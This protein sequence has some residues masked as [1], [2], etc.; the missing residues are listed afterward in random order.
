MSGSEDDDATRKGKV[1]VVAV[2]T[3]T[4]QRWTRG[5]LRAVILCECL[6][7]NLGDVMLT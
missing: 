4:L 7:G 2:A 1:A 3:E 5:L 6:R